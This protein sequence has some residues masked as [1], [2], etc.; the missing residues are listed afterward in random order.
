MSLFLREK[1]HVAGICTLGVRN[2]SKN[3]STWLNT[4]KYNL[5]DTIKKWYL[6][7]DLAVVCTTKKSPTPV[8]GLFFVRRILRFEPTGSWF[9][10]KRQADES[11]PKKGDE[12][13]FYLTFI[14]NKCVVR[15]NKRR[16][17]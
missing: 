12:N 4:F 8:A 15:N 14:Q 2:G 11:M 16:I 1:M 6:F 3:M 13:I 17:S 10:H 9:D 5:S 7:L